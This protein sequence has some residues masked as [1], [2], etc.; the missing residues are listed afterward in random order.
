[1]NCETKKGL[2]EKKEK[3][4]KIKNKRTTIKRKNKRKKLREVAR[5]NGKGFFTNKLFD[6]S[7]YQVPS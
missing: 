2:T 6:F 4:I 7:A 1:M 3:E 5:N